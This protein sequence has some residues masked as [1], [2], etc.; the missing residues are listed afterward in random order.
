MGIEEAS[1]GGTVLEEEVVELGFED[2]HAKLA[3]LAL[4]LGQSAEG[5]Q[6]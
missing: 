1:G 3:V 2:L 4:V 5:R 6:H